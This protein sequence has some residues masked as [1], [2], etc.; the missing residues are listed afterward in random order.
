MFNDIQIRNNIISPHHSQFIHHQLTDHPREREIILT[1]RLDQSENR[2]NILRFLNTF[3]KKSIPL[4]Q[5]KNPLISTQLIPLPLLLPSQ[6]TLLHHKRN[7][8][9]QW[10]IMRINILIPNTIPFFTL[11]S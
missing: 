2:I 1:N 10:I 3:I 9:N 8:F 11:R 5:N 7:S 4:L 6:I